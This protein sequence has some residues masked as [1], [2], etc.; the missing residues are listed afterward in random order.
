M[1]PRKLPCSEYA[2]ELGIQE[3]D[4]CGTKSGSMPAYGLTS[5]WSRRAAAPGR[6]AVQVQG[7]PDF[8]TGDDHPFNH[9]I[10]D[11]SRLVFEAWGH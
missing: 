4:R 7:E 2:E 1:I 8:N 10:A 11:L 3:Y 5:A 6:I 9:V